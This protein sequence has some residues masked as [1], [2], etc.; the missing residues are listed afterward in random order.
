M[1]E[2][3]NAIDDYEI[4]NFGNCRKKLKNG[5]YKDIKGSLMTTPISKTYKLRY[6]QLQRNGKRIN[7]LFHHLVAK[8]FISDRPD[9]MVIDHIDRNPLNNN[10]SNLRYITQ[11]ENCY[12]SQ[13]VIDTNIPI[14][15]PN[16]KRLVQ[17][18]WEQE[19]RDKMLQTK[20]DYYTNNKDKWVA[21][22][23]IRKQDRVDLKCIKCNC[24][25]NIQRNSIRY[26]KSEICS[27]CNSL[28]QLQKINENKKINLVM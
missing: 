22:G 2:W 5:T 16:R 28:I 3:K 4:S 7:Y 19:N 14:D 8:C 11:K 9:G 25:Y 15:T 17:Q 10:V 1:E 24:F 6:F 20:R 23:D 27:K 21:E 26:K 12:N 13:R 18:K